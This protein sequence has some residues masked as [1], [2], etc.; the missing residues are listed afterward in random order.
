MS[1]DDAE[2]KDEE[3]EAAVAAVAAEATTSAWDAA[4]AAASA[5]DADASARASFEAVAADSGGA[6][7]TSDAQRQ[8]CRE[9]NAKVWTLHAVIDGVSKRRRSVECLVQN[10]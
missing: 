2:D 10:C 7:A 4:S 3:E 9:E 5:S 1:V 6:L 8:K